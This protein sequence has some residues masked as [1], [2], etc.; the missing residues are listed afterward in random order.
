[1][2]REIHN[3]TTKEVVRARALGIFTITADTERG[4]VVT[5]FRS[6]NGA[7]PVRLS[8]SGECVRPRT[9]RRY[10]TQLVRNAL[11]GKT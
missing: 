3:L 6:K 11:K 9:A 5:V 8:Q 10:A 1:M 2:N 7:E 4:Y